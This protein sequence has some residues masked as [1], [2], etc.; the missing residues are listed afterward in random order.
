MTPTA[1]SPQAPRTAPGFFA[2]LG[3]FL[4]RAG[5]GARSRRAAV[6][7]VASLV[8]V[9]GVFGLVAAPALAS[10]PTILLNSSSGNELT[11]YSTRASATAILG[12]GK[13]ETFDGLKTHWRFEYATSKTGP[14]TVADNV[15]LSETPSQTEIE[16]LEIGAKD[17]T[18]RLELHHLSPNTLYYGRYV[19]ENVEGKAELPIE[20]KTLDI[21]RPEIATNS[22]NTEEGRVFEHTSF[23]GNAT[24]PSAAAFKAQVESNGAETKYGFEYAPAESGHAPVENSPSWAL[25]SSGATGTITVAEDF[26]NPEAHLTGLAPETTY[27]VRL[28]ATNSQGTLVETEPGI[29]GGEASER[30]NF[31]TTPPAKPLV[32]EPAARNVTAT[33]VYLTGEFLPRG[34]K[35]RWRFEYAASLIGPWTV[36][37]GAAG[38]VSQAEAEALPEGSSAPGVEGSLAGLSP[39]TT[40]Y[41]RL[42]AENECAVGAVGCGEGENEFGEQ[43]SDEARGVLSVK[44]TGPPAASTLAVH[45]FD[46]ESTRL[47]AAVSPE[48]PDTSGEQT[49]TIGGAPTG[50]T[51]TL[52]FEGQTTSPIAFDASAEDGEASVKHALDALPSIHREPEAEVQVTG[53]DG[54]PYTVYFGADPSLAGRAV[55][56]IEA[57]ASGLVPSGTSTIAVATTLQGGGGY[58]THYHFQ[59]V[60]QG[61][62]AQ[63]AWS[64]AAS[65]PEVDLGSGSATTVV[66][67]DLPALQPGETYRYRVLATNTSPGNPVVTGAVQTLTVPA[68]S[69]AGG[70]AAA[71]PNE[72]FRTGPSANLPDCRAYEQVTPVD[73]EGAQEIFN[74]GITST[75]GA[76]IGEDGEHV[77]L[78]RELVKLGN[79]AGPLAGQSPYFFSRDPQK[80]WQ[81]TAAASQPETGV[82][83]DAPQL[84]NPDLTQ[85][86]F[87]TGF[88]TSGNKSSE[89]GFKTGPPGGPYVPVAS[90]PRKQVAQD[91]GWV[92]ASEDFSKLI[93]QV[94]D[95][96][97][98]EPSTATKSG[99]DLYEYAG[100]ELRQVN[101][102]GG[103]PGSAIGSCGA[104]IVHGS[105]SGEGLFSS[106]HAVSSDGSRVF[107]EAVPGNHCSEVSH[108]YVRVNG[109]ETV[110]IGAVKFLAAN[111]EGTNVLLERQTGEV[112]EILLYDSEKQTTKLLFSTYQD[113]DDLSFTVSEDLTAIYFESAGQLTAEAPSNE[114]LDLYRYD[115]ATETLSFVVQATTVNN[116]FTS[117]DGRYAYFESDGVGGVPGGSGHDEVTGLADDA[118]QVYR[119][120]SS[121]DVVQCMSCASSFDPSPK[122]LATFGSG[123][124]AGAKDGRADSQNGLPKVTVA[125]ADGDYVFFDTPAALVASDVDGEVEPE[126]VGAEHASGEYSV[127][128][129][130][131]EWRRDGVDGCAHPQGCLALI[132]SG[133]GGLLNIFLGASESG[134]DVFFYTNSQ[135]LQ[136]DND[137]AG[138]IYDA[139]IGGGFPPPPPGA[140]ECEGDACSTPFAPPGGVTPASLAFSGAGNLTPAVAPAPET[141]AKAKKVKAKKK[142]KT[143]K[144]SRSKKQAKKSDQRRGK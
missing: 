115:I 23:Q 60:S 10:P 2:V 63:S 120:D 141:K 49:V 17:A 127:S 66:G 91:S 111:T 130:V 9:A 119:Y 72:Q 42:F 86:A 138:D 96:E 55:P 50:G 37:P 144:K 28:K 6:A 71:C 112:H 44:T 29:G 124:G 16:R 78:E 134:R 56:R 117:P 118:T 102:S 21:V 67:Q 45:A 77:V 89:M 84:F 142:R 108:L 3:A 33:S 87:E 64:E 48:S 1:H 104:K 74:Y 133:R 31:F 75:G 81:M 5:S 139:R 110:D 34:S 4:H 101:V 39:A 98:V 126:G 57:H 36:V 125:S 52:T 25:F 132:T 62:F 14:W 114:R 30:S 140:V 70:E 76:M 61:K 12:P 113:S 135:L 90:V 122:L 99:S 59:Y 68:V 15:T 97:L 69:E 85:F 40:Y 53:P 46:L 109:V 105:E 27:Y 80:G 18:L 47:L 131:Y 128:S 103:S 32:F 92:A 41:V 121:E 129:D 8:T 26:A 116:V 20:F 88:D 11:A 24:S 106:S 13:F 107:F 43:V 19:V 51:F 65:T 123:R 35:T 38:T 143:K 93:L 136:Q 95:R 79:G 94:E 58:D 54:G 73:K 82:N 7:A 22:S 137:T 100:G 83:Y